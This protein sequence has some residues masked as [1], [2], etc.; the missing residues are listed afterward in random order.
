MPKQFFIA[1]D[2]LVNTLFGGYA[3]ETLFAK[4]YRLHTD[5]RF[6][7]GLKA[8]IDMLFFWQ[9]GHCYHSWLSEEETR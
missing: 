8:V 3:D 6:W 5:S 2:Q 7:L 9:D 1:I 4:S